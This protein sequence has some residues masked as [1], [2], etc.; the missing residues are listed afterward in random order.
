M[1]QKKFIDMM[2]AAKGFYLVFLFFLAFNC[3][4]AQ[5][6]GLLWRVSGKG[7]KNASYLFG[8]IHMHCQDENIRKAE[9]Q[10]AMD[11]SS[12]VAMELN[13]NDYQTFVA[14]MK[15]NMKLSG[16]SLKSMLS[17]PEYH[18]VDSICKVFTGTSLEDFDHKP[19]MTVLASIMMSKDFVGCNRP[20]PVDMVIADM[21]K[22][23]GKESYGLES[24]SFQDS[25]LGSIPDS[26][27]IRWLIEFCGDIPQ[28]KAEFQ[29]LLKAYDSQQALALYDIILKTSPEL[30]LLN[31]ALLVQ[32]NMRWVEFLGNN[33]K[34]NVYFMAVGAGHLGG[35]NGLISL[36]RRAGYT[37]TP[38]QI[39]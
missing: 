29:A 13:L 25:L 23:G 32:R 17:I 34:Y 16:K 38:V 33:M 26:T 30:I 35:D 11:S 39:H 5:S 27:Q 37:V 9:I 14:M 10:S 28:A 2:S 21:A 36:L 3:L 18:L 15:A 4:P 1:Q 6:D 12:I 24:F 20:L 7:L 19:P 31:D 22:Q 8:T